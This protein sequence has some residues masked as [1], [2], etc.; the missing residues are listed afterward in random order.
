[1][2]FKGNASTFTKSAV[3]HN[4]AWLQRSN[5]GTRR[6]GKSSGGVRTLVYLIFESANICGCE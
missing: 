5:D 2:L 4:A 1:M 6:S 3:W